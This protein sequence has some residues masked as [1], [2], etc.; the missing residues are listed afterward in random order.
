[1]VVL[2]ERSR[3][4]CTFFLLFSDEKL[5]KTNVCYNGG[6]CVDIP[7]SFRCHCDP[8]FTGVNCRVN[9]DECESSPCYGGGRCKDGI[10]S[11]T[12][13][14]TQDRYGALCESKYHKRF[15]YRRR[16]LPE[17]ENIGSVLNL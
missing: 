14:C 1:M 8:G 7:G 5:C 4:I 16:V 12:C 3:V 9:I 6:K 15:V 11:F 13:R 10:N 2:D 17:G